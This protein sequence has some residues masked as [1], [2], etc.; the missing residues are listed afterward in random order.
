VDYLVVSGRSPVWAA[1][2]AGRKILTALQ[3]QDD[4]YDIRFVRESSFLA[5]ARKK[6]R[7]HRR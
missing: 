2:A 1:G 4:G 7:H 5:A 3:L 6:P